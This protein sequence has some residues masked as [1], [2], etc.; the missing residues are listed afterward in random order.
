MY[1]ISNS[2]M[3]NNEAAGYGSS[4][5]EN[6]NESDNDSYRYIHNIR[7]RPVS[8]IFLPRDEVVL[9]EE[10][11]DGFRQV[12]LA[13][14]KKCD[15]GRSSVASVAAAAAALERMG[16]Y[17]LNEGNF[18]NFF[19]LQFFAIFLVQISLIFFSEGRKIEN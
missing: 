3:Y 16:A 9:S 4:D 11:R 12:H 15:G 17:E 7:L 2:L 14:S 1:S 6:E 10:H 5:S 18:D 13:A 19:F 8:T